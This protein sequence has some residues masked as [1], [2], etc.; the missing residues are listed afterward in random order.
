VSDEPVQNPHDGLVRYIFSDAQQMQ[1]LL[2]KTLPPAVLAELDMATLSPVSGSFVDDALRQQHSDLLYRVSFLN[3]KEGFVYVLFEHK[4]YQDAML[5]FQLLRYMVRIWERLVRDG[6]PLNPIIP[7]M[8][9][10][11]QKAWISS[12]TMQDIIDAPEE[13]ERFLPR[14]DSV[15]ID[16]SQCSDSEL[17][18]N[19]L[20]NA[21]LLML[22]YVASEELGDRLPGIIQLLVQ[23]IDEP[24]GLECL[25]AVLVYL[26]NATDKISHEQLA[27][28]VLQAFKSAREERESPMP[29][30]AETL[31]QQG[32]EK[33]MEKGLRAGI[34][35]G[36]RV[37]IRI[38]L[39]LRFPDQGQQL[40]AQTN[41][42]HSTELLTEFLELCKT[43]RSSEELQSFLVQA[44]QN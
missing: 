6:S 16:L 17:R 26:T 28:T 21:V 36:L 12:R 11:G 38:A 42:M 15:L 27:T 33:G 9:Y 20:L 4:S 32:I 13:L 37:G 44:N 7:L 19:A 40:L 22:K 1:G 25:K 39:D 10:H 31:I 43:A 41:S 14:F 2:T 18:G 30:I 8:L 23:I 29:T 3:G 35:K 34:R 5:P 24:R